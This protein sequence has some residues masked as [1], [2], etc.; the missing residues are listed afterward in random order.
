M[1]DLLVLVA[2][3]LTTIVKLLKPGGTRAVV[4]ESLLLIGTK[5]RE[6]LDHVL[7]WNRFDLRRKLNEFKTYYNQGRIHSSL[8][9]KTPYEQGGSCPPK[10]VDLGHFTWTACFL[11]T[12]ALFLSY[13]PCFRVVN[14]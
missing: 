9:G 1:K 5:R 10:L 14:R 6:Y 3:L 11:G 12:G 4:A 13:P 2:H 8:S 7:F